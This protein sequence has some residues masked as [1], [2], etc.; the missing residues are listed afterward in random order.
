MV[1]AFVYDVFRIRRKAVKT[2]GLLV[3]IEDLIFWIIA[4]LVMFAVVY[5]SNEGEVRGYIF[6][7]TLLGVVL[8]ALLLSKIVINSSIFV[9]KVIYRVL[10]VIWLVLSRPFIILFRIFRVPA[11]LVY[12]VFAK[13][14]GNMKRIGKS[15]LAKAAMWNKLFKNSRK[16]I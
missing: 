12:R 6:L 9:L 16:K 1:I 4:A 15:R 8:Y 13:L 3:Y 2:I 5:F 11:R 14:L 7:G 10:R